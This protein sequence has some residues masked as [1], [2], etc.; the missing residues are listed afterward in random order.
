MAGLNYGNLFDRGMDFDDQGRARISTNG[1]D[2]GRYK[3]IISKQASVDVT[4]TSTTI[5]TV[6]AGKVFY[7]TS[8]SLSF[9]AWGVNAQANAWIRQNTGE[10]YILWIA[11]PN[12]NT[13]LDSGN[14]SLSCPTPIKFTAGETIDVQKGATTGEVAS[15][16]IQ[17]WIEDA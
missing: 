17:G 7:L 10:P 3:T 2:A 13:S 12:T 5:Y 8:A 6:P 4:A 16:T 15:A 14:N 9:C 11:L 1:E